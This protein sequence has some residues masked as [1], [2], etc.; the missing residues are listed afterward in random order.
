MGEAGPLPLKVEYSRS[1][2]ASCKVC[3]EKIEKDELR[4]AKMVQSTHFD[5]LQENWH[6][7]PCFLAKAAPFCAAD[8]EGLDSLRWEDQETLR[9]KIES[10]A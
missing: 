5:G 4:V 8:V 10:C 3:G 7:L 1:N 2:R 6:H 9:K